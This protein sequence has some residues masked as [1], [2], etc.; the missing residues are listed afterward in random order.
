V[1]GAG[2]GR[3]IDLRRFPDDGITLLGRLREVS[4][5]RIAFAEDLE[6][7]LAEGDAWFEDLRTE[8]DA[9]AREHPSELPEEPSP[10]GLSSPAPGTARPIAELETASGLG[11]VIWATGFR[12]NFDWVKLPVLGASGEP[13]Q[14]R[15]VSSCRGFYFLGLRRM[16]NLR[17][18]LFE[19]VGDDAAHIAE[20][21]NAR[22][23]LCGRPDPICGQGARP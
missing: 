9:Y 15:G 3:D 22:E 21:I 2:G 8:M 10:D 4:A 16:F 20:H 1:T 14:T 17:S 7:S 23:L 5:E 6:Q 19:G 18:N 13:L 11:A 12:Y